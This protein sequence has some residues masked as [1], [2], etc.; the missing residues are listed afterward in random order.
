MTFWPN[1]NWSIRLKKPISSEKPIDRYWISAIW[2]AIKTERIQVLFSVFIF[3]CWHLAFFLENSRFST[4]CQYLNNYMLCFVNCCL[5]TVRGGGETILNVILPLFVICKY[6]IE[7]FKM[8]LK[9]ELVNETNTLNV[10][11]WNDRKT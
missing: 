11:Y 5:R 2:K 4:P 6:E 3:H 8:V 1:S 9:F 10:E 7:N